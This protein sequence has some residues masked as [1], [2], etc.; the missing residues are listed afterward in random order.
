MD[1]ALPITAR[2]LLSFSIYLF[3]LL[4]LSHILIQGVPE[5]PTRIANYVFWGKP[6]A[7]LFQRALNLAVVRL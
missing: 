7:P 2:F 6:G 4:F 3:L 5:H 1:M